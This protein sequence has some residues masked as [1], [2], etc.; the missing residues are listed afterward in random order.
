[1]NKKKVNK[2]A[3]NNE[4]LLNQL[5]EMQK[6]KQKQKENKLNVLNTNMNKKQDQIN[7]NNTYVTTNHLDH[8]KSFNAPKS[9]VT[10]N[11]NVSINNEN[12]KE[13]NAMNM[14]L[15]ENDQLGLGEDENVKAKKTI[16]RLKL[17]EKHL[18]FTEK[19]MK[20]LYTELMKQEFNSTN[21]ASNL[22]HFLKIIKTWHFLLH[23]KMEFSFF[24]S[25]IRDLGY[26]AAV[27]VSKLFIK[28]I[29]VK[30][31]KNL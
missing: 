3:I 2:Y 7:Q 14:M 22:S 19:G 20:F 6:Q 12:S 17:D 13:K 27:R 24:L 21:P 16:N 29:Y 31:E 10:I 18:L 1:M 25:K 11:N 15:G 8:G 23:S 4:T 30:I 9:N 5:A 28:G 26:K